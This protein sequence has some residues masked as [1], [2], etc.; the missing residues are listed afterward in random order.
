MAPGMKKWTGLLALCLALTTAWALPIRGP[1]RIEDRIEWPD[2]VRLRELSQEIQE[3]HEIL[4]H[5]RKANDLSGRIAASSAAGAVALFPDDMEVPEEARDVFQAALRQEV[6]ALPGRSDVLVGYA[7]VDRNSGAVPNL[8]APRLELG[9]EFYVGEREGQPYCIKVREVGGPEYFSRAFYV[10][11]LR[12]S[13]ANHRSNVLAACRAYAI[14]GVPGEHITKWLSDGAMVF[15]AAAPQTPRQTGGVD[16]GRTMPFGVRSWYSGRHGFDME[17][18]LASDAEACLDRY[19]VKENLRDRREQVWAVVDATPLTGF[20]DRGWRSPL[21]YESRYLFADLERAFGVDAF[22]AF[23]TS[24]E[25]VPQAFQ[26]AFG[27]DMGPWLLSWT[28]ERFGVST[29]GPHLTRKAAGG[30][31]LAI[32]LSSLLAA[33]WSRRRTVA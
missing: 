30:G 32:V 19:T 23:W 11:N 33:A 16:Y 24:D 14:Y 3:K 4:R 21:D 31:L 18:C 22:R 12:E 28:Q 13:M 1:H 25:E 20:D 26:D 6:E 27:A 17:R 9:D 5:L 8:G 10:G 7:Y 15:G 29:P 2:E